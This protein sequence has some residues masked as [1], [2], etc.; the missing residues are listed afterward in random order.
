[1]C[2][3]V[4]EGALWDMKV[5]FVMWAMLKDKRRRIRRRSMSVLCE[6]AVEKIEERERGPL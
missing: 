1:M 5:F 2:F 6:V 4:H 3:V